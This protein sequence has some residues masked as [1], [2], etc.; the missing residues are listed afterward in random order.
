MPGIGDS[1]HFL[2][3]PSPS[4]VIEWSPTPSAQPRRLAPRPR[5]LVPATPEPSQASSLVQRTQTQRGARRQAGRSAPGTRFRFSAAKY[6]MTYSQIGDVDNGTLC[7]F[8]ADFSVPIKHWKAVEE[9][10]V[11]GGRHWHVIVVF[12]TAFRGR[13]ERI[14]DIEGIH[15]NIHISGNK[16]LLAKW[17]YIHKEEGAALLGP[18]EGPE[19]I[20]V[21][22]DIKK[23]D[24]RWAHILEASS[25]DE[26][27]ERARALAPYDYTIN[28]DRIISIGI[29]EMEEWVETQFH[30]RDRP[31]CLVLY[32]PS[33]TGKTQWAR[34]LNHIIA[35]QEGVDDPCHIGHTCLYGPT[36]SNAKKIDETAKYI[37]LDDI[38]LDY[39]PSYKS[40]FGGQKEFEVTDKY[41]SKMTV[42]WG[43]PCI[44]LSN[45]DPRLKKIDRPW[46]EANC[47]FAEVTNPLY[48][49]DDGNVPIV[50]EEERAYGPLIEDEDP[51]VY[52]EDIPVIRNGQINVNITYLILRGTPAF[53]SVLVDERVNNVI[54][55]W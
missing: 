20:T 11:D 39:F 38:D 45:E 53:A 19:P 12:E 23:K 41:V 29:P 9:H 27:M 1:R 8:F 15:P 32:G 55:V 43:K 28:H 34:A 33:R 5:V 52:L 40:F 30:N 2:N 10:H 17:N 14:F 22:T 37:V 50:E 21:D 44:W 3:P 46:I 25:A 31:K 4:P 18:W 26:F 7:R 16:D 42:R 36:S 24:D 35:R 13:N 54:Y 49:V 47:I 48:D 51:T 6:F